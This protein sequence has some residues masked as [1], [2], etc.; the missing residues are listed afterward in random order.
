M[1]I[2]V[3]TQYFYPETFRINDLCIELVNR[4]HE[5]HVLTGYPQYPQGR[6]YEGYGFNMPYKTQWNGIHIHRVKMRPRGKTPLGLLWNCYSFVAQGNKWVKNCK[7]HFDIVFVFEV[8]PVTVGLPALT[9]KEK[10]QTPMLFNLQDLW[11]ENVIHVLGIRNKFVIRFID[12]I[13]DKIYSGSDKILCSSNS[14]R[15]AV[16]ARG[17]AP[18]KCI[19]WPQFCEW[20]DVNTMTKPASYDDDSF[21]IAFAGNIGEAQGLDLLIEAAG[22]LKEKSVKWHIVGD[23]RAKQRL[24]EKAQ[25]AQVLDKVVFVG[26]VSEAEANQYIH[27]ADCAYLSFSDNVIFDMTIPAKMQTYLACGTPILAAVSGESADIVTKGNC[28]LVVA[29]TPESVCAGVEELMELDPVAIND[30]RANCI[31]TFEDSFTKERVVDALE[32]VM[33]KVT[34]TPN[35]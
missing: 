33:E 13:V 6:I 4:G 2:L 20:P 29:R 17:V 35:S 27:Y 25:Q 22:M 8:S 7:E 3:V 32:G 15:N 9:Y 31:Q 21:H 14:F 34:H 12:R 5:V 28:G 26:K 1:K 10:F 30:I 11:P 23:G 19:F 24:Y 18:E 16:T